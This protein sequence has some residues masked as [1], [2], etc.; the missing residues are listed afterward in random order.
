MAE[1]FS[2][3]GKVE[4]LQQDFPERTSPKPLS[5]CA[6]VKTPQN[7]DYIGFRD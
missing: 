7:G 5:M 6:I 2:A 4:G 3:P 1:F